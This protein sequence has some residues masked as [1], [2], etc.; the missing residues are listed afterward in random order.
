[1]ALSD[2]KRSEIV[3]H[4]VSDKKLL[5]RQLRENGLESIV[6]RKGIL[7]SAILQRELDA[8]DA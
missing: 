5:R 1:M 7:Q 6:I 4:F 8:I 2:E 3:D